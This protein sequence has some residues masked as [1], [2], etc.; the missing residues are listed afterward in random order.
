MKRYGRAGKVVLPATI[1]LSVALAFCATSCGG[2]SREESVGYEGPRYPPG[3][4]EEMLVRTTGSGLGSLAEGAEGSKASAEGGDRTTA[5]APGA[6]AELSGVRFTVVEATRPDSNAVVVTSGQREV[7]GDYLEIELLAENGSGDIADL[8]EF[9]FR[10]RGPHVKA[11][12]Y[13]AYYGDDPR[14]GKY[15]S[16][17]TISGVLLDYAT[18]RPAAC[19]LKAGEVL[20]GVFLFF[21]LNPRST[22][23]NQEMDKDNVKLV[24]RKLRG[25]DAGEEVEISLSGYP[26]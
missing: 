8:G 23:R 26:D 20:D 7:P 18:L 2:A 9:S 12:A 4:D 10:L 6:T 16:E 22:A 13:E 24:I 15:V 5:T 11:D 21:D 17:D 14:F 1:V 19:K 25:E 3:T